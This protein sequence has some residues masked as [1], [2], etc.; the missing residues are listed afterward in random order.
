MTREQKLAQVRK[1]IEMRFQEGHSCRVNFFKKYLFITL[2]YRQLS[3]NIKMK[4]YEIK[5]KFVCPGS[6]KP[7]LTKLILIL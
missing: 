5:T 2:Y 7:G 4:N 3:A 1:E 6:L